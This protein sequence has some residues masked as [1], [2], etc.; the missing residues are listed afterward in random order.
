MQ[1][2][3]L[4]MTFRQ[5]NIPPYPKFFAVSG[6]NLSF[7]TSLQTPQIDQQTR[8]YGT[9]PDLQKPG[10]QLEYCMQWKLH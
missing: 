1:L 8:I 6:N 4:L 7:N 10:R 2:L 3:Y 5:L 9:M